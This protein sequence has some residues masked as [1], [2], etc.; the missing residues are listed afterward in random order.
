MEP[1]TDVQEAV[2]HLAN[3]LMHLAVNVQNE[4]GHRAVQEVIDMA[5]DAKMAVGLGPMNDDAQ[6]TEADDG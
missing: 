2:M 3:A 4:A 5:A 1:L 6:T